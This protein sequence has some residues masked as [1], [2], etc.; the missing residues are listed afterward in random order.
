MAPLVLNV[1]DRMFRGL[2]LEGPDRL[3]G[4]EGDRPLLWQLDCRCASLCGITKLSRCAA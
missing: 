1:G 4:L 3:H 2:M